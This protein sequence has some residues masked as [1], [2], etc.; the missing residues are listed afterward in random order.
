MSKIS[1]EL[2]PIAIPGSNPMIVATACS[3]IDDAMNAL[4][5]IMNE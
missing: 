5:V 1:H 3:Y 2:I 4:K